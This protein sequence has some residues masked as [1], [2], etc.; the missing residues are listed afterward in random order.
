[1]LGW[2]LDVS[3]GMSAG[4][5]G[6]RV[7][8]HRRG[9]PPRPDRLHRPPAPRPCRRSAGAVRPG[10]DGPLCLRDAH[11]PLEDVT[12]GMGSSVSVEA[13]RPDLSRRLA[14]EAVG[15]A[16]LLATVVGSGIMG[17]RL[18]GGNVAVALLANTLATGAVLVAL[19]TDVRADLRRALQP[20]GH[21]RG[22]VAGRPA[23]ARRAGL[24]RGPGRRRVRRGR[25]GARDVRAAALLRLA[26]R[27]RTARRRCSASSSR[28][29][30]CWR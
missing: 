25:G 27:A 7:P 26:P 23:L 20:R 4:G 22:C 5:L 2:I 3:G 30:A 16:L 18:A 14:A 13:E 21:A 8:P 6:A 24:R 28:R 9:G 29:S 15:T 12:G 10:P 17:E 11:T 19:I 1:M